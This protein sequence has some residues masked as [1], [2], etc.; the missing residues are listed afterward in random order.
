MYRLNGQVVAARSI[1][2]D[3]KSHRAWLGIDAPIPG[4]MTT[5]YDRDFAICEALV[6]EAAKAAA[7]R[8]FTD[9]EAAKAD[10]AG[11]AYEGFRRLGFKPINNRKKFTLKLA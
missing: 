2:V 3:A 5:E 10:R 8:F 9:I 4:Y 1:F 6:A 7:Q 11:P